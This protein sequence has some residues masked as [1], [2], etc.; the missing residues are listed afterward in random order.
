MLAGGALPPVLRTLIVATIN[1]TPH[2]LMDGVV[3]KQDVTPGTDA[4]ARRLSVTGVDLTAVMG[5]IDFSGMPFP[6]DADRGAGRADRSPSTRCS[7]SCRW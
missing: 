6:A 3:T 7:A 1:G 2:V 5:L 4:S